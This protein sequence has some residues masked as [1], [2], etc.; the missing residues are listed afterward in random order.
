MTEFNSRTPTPLSVI[1]SLPAGRQASREESLNFM[2]QNYFV[3]IITNKIHTVLYT[4]M[5]NNLRRRMQEHKEKLVDGFTKRYNLNKLI[6]YEVFNSPEFAILAEKK[7]K[8]WTRIKKEVLIKENNPDFRD[9][10][11]D[12]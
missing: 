5:T 3:Y 1:L 7:I 8:G 4:G 6:F 12:L 9:L 10:S 2:N 11:L